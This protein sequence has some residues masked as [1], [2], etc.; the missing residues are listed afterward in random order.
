[1]ALEPGGRFF[2]SFSTTHWPALFNDSGRGLTRFAPLLDRSGAVVPT[3]YGARTRT[4]ALLEGVFHDVHA[5]GR[6]DIT[7]LD[8][9]RRGL[10][11]FSLPGRLALVDLRDEALGRLGFRRGHLVTAPSQHYRCTGEWA[12]ALHG[13]GIGSAKPVGLLWRSRV[14]ELARADS[15]LFADLLPGASK[16][17][18]VL[19]GDLLNTTDPSAY[20]PLAESDDLSSPLALRLLAPIAQELGATLV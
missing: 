14:A 9:Q 17:V 1:V 20:A 7:A 2:T 16:E 10:A 6:R 13:R 4:V 8:L 18:F 3:L 12:A 19:F 11:A 15:A 5:T